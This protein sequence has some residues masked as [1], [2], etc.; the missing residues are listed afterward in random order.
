MFFE[1]RLVTLIII[2]LDSPRMKRPFSVLSYEYFEAGLC[3]C[4]R[5]SKH[6]STHACFTSDRFTMAARSLFSW[7]VEE[8]ICTQTRSRSASKS[9]VNSDL[10]N[11]PAHGDVLS[12]LFG[13]GLLPWSLSSSSS[14][15]AERN[16][17]SLRAPCLFIWPACPVPGWQSCSVAPVPT[18]DE[19]L[20]T[21]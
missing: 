11:T 14:E 1:C 7:M 20:T 21:Q 6:S 16:H 10:P 12:S 13:L 3:L 9:Y 15:R 8:D 4:T 19:C 17:R 2:E 18:P 5:A